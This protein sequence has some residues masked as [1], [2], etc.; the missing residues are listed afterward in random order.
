MR[1][2]SDYNCC[3]RDLKVTVGRI[4]RANVD[5]CT[6]Y[7]ARRAI[8]YTAKKKNISMEITGRR[9]SHINLSH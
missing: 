7:R 8:S 6:D 4:G 2:F 1:I 3:H 5:R 9:A